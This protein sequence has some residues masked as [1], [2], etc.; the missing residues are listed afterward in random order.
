MK[1]FLNYYRR[2][3][4]KLT[5]CDFSSNRKIIPE[6]GGIYLDGVNLK[7]LDPKW[8]RNDIIGYIG[9]EPCLFSGSIYE[10]IKYGKPNATKEEVL[11]GM[12]TFKIFEIFLNFFQRRKKQMHMNLY[13]N[14]RMDM[15]L[16]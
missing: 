1:L 13:P 16:Q 6:K 2:L 5:E 8:L 12:Q 15:P 7:K 10:N 11:E 9:Q 3:Y 14:S 4:K